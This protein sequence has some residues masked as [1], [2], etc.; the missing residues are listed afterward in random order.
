MTLPISK[1]FSNSLFYFSLALGVFILSS[2][3]GCE[4]GFNFGSKKNP[5]LDSEDVEKAVLIQNAVREVYNEVN[6]SVVRIETEQKIKSSRHPFLLDPFFRRFFEIPEN[7]QNRKGLGSGFVLNESGHIVTNYHVV[8]NVDLIKIKFVDG[9]VYEALVE[10][11]D[12]PS[13][14]ALLKI[15]SEGEERLR[16]KPV[17]IGNSE[18]LFVGDTVFAIG[19]PFGLSSTLTMGVV[20]STAQEIYTADGV[21]RIQVDAAINPGNSGGPLLDIYGRVVGINQMIYTANQKPG[22][23]G[24]AFSIP[25]NYAVDIIKKLRS[26]KEIAR[27]YIGIQVFAEAPDNELYRLGINRSTNGLLVHRVIKDSPAWR[28]GI[29]PFDFI[30]HLDGDPIEK[31]SQFRSLIARK[32]VG[33]TITVQLI[34]KGLSKTVRI[35][36]GKASHNE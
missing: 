16:L 33:K 22:F 27:P 26:G 31:F 34:R 29:R 4:E 12:E 23:I 17:Q 9:R 5:L 11:H 8:K 1:Y 7:S 3:A 25:I 30:T 35:R 32:E 19:N 24:I 28:S 15:E 18:D 20:S 2:C 10:G 21:P 13:D 36:V 14:L 6:P